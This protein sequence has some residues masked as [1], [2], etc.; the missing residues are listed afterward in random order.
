MRIKV[1]LVDDELEFVEM[2]SERLSARGFSVSKALDG[3]Q[4][5]LRLS[6]VG[7]DVVVLDVQMPG[8]DGLTVLREIRQTSP[9]T[10]VLMLTGHATVESAV[11]GIRAGAYDF[12][13]KPAEMRDLV[14]KIVAA[15]TR[16][17][18]REEHIRAAGIERIMLRR[19]WD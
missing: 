4:A 8:M 16:K 19:G 11:E 2:L 3:R 13:L 12:I 14:E 10:E 18:G 1:L 15:Y 6:E 7:P 9:L 5:L 17:S